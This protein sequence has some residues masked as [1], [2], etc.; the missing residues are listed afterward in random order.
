MYCT[1]AIHALYIHYT[2][3]VHVLYMCYTCAIHVL[4]VHVCVHYVIILLYYSREVPAGS[5]VLAN[6]LEA[7]IGSIYIDSGIESCKTVLAGLLFPEQA[8][9]LLFYYLF[10]ILPLG[11]SSDMVESI[12]GSAT[13]KA[14]HMTLV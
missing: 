2:C 3:S 9:Q 11:S 4:R 7:V 1:Y 5:H 13:G 12:Q 8:S 14:S 6:A 10:F